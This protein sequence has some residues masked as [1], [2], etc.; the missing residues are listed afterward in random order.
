MKLERIS[1]SQTGV[2][3]NCQ[4]AWDYGYRQRIVA[5]TGK[6][7]YDLGTLI[8][9]LCAVYDQNLKIGIPAGSDIAWDRVRQYAVDTWWADK[10]AM[11][12]MD[13]VALFNRAMSC[14]KKYILE[15]SGTVDTG[16]VMED[17]EDYFELP[18]VTPK[19]RTIIIEGYID[20]THFNKNGDRV[21]MDRKTNSQG[22]HRSDNQMLIDPQLTLYAAAYREMGRPVKMVAIESMS[23]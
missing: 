17:I 4:Q 19:G 1:H 23:T 12:N 13:R 16:C 21:L 5:K 22:R 3:S 20:R 10:D 11:S 7:Y 15:F 14:V 2:W 6:T 18:I 8:H 9:E